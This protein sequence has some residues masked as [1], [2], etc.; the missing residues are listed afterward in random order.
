MTKPDI[1][2]PETEV[3]PAKAPA[4]KRRRFAQDG[5]LHGADVPI[6][7]VATM[8]LCVVFAPISRH[9]LSMRLHRE[10]SWAETW[11]AMGA[12]WVIVILIVLWLA[13]L[14]ERNKSVAKHLGWNVGDG[15][16]W[17]DVD[18][19]PVA[20]PGGSAL[21]TGTYGVW[22]GRR[23]ES[24]V[25]GPAESGGS[26][27]IAR[28]EVMELPGALPQLEIAPHGKNRWAAAGGGDDLDVE[29]PEFNEHFRVVTNRREYAHAVLH[30]R[31]MERLMREDARE[32]AITIVGQCVMVWSV[33]PASLKNV[34]QRLDVMADVVDL[35]PAFVYDQWSDDGDRLRYNEPV[36]PPATEG[37]NWLGWASLVLSFTILLAPIGLV[38]GHRGLRAIRHGKATNR[39]ITTFALIYGYLMVLV[40]VIATIGAYIS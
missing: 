37:K 36:V 8:A 6:I 7:M 1:D 21:I 25:I 10:V 16:L 27:L 32:L 18:A 20:V 33:P 22:R 2:S 39:P 34:K 38:V 9:R 29:S 23:A 31:M 15:G 28:V 13:R 11:W 26:L 5:E 3:T 19:I 24:D 35:I 14:T 40:L 4:P 12:V 30:P 17:R